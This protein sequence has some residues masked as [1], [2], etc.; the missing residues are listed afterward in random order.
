VNPGPTALERPLF[1]TPA[2][3]SA[4]A[5]AR[6]TAILVGSYDGSGNYGDIAQ[7]DAALQ[8]L[9]PLD[10]GF[11]VLPVL[12][13]GFLHGHREM[14]ATFQQP[15]DH[16]LFYD[17]EGAWED[18]LL[19]VAAPP[20]LAAAAIYLYG[21]GY[22]NPSWGERKLGMTRV[23]D[24]LL[25]SA[26]VEA[27]VRLTS[28]L[29]VDPAW[30]N[31]F[32][33][34]DL[35]LL[36][37]FELLGARDPLSARALADLGATGTVLETGDDAL[38]AI[39]EVAAGNGPSPT[40]GEIQVNLHFAEHE[41]VSGRP[42]ELREVTLDLI[43][44]LGRR[45]GR[46]VRVRPLIAYLDG[47]IDERPGLAAIAREA[48]RRGI[49]VDEPRVLRPS[50][51]EEELPG[52]E[53]AVATISCSYHVA[54]TSLL[55]GVPTVVFADN[56]Y[57]RQKA[58]GLVSAFG[59]PPSF[60]YSPGADPAAV[61]TAILD[62]GEG[63]RGEIARHGG[64][65]RRTREGAEI[66]LLARLA[67]GVIA[68]MSTNARR[69]DERVR[70]RSAEPAALRV[71]LAAARTEAEELRRPAIEAA[72]LAADASAEEAREH[73]RQAEE[74]TAQAE[75]NTGRAEADAAAAHARLAELLGSRS[76][77]IGTPL[78][79]LGALL[80]RLRP[81]RHG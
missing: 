38:G 42:G 70:E 26:G 9:K 68:Q 61:S 12:E 81:R 41:W 31:S 64:D 45:A 39:P 28:G 27:P 59:L 32:A 54:L 17:P 11:L 69:L 80:R 49:E 19:P 18:D 14:L 22:L 65:L 33:P 25:A 48:E 73:V 78:R 57:Y 24:N 20:R 55:L 51:L 21:G 37:S 15:F 4:I 46:T 75:A 35:D 3:L 79:K 29:Q 74:R 76:W 43:E 67:A 56:D 10:P 6:A 63:L 30:L 1:A 62:G 52:L 66:E 5:E 71:E 13:R 2:T 58:A 36:R 8:L 60:A 72:I 23:A 77:R 34:A 44:E 16:A 50:G 47:R 53:R 40:Q 7:L